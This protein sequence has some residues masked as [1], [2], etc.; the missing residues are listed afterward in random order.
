MRSYFGTAISKNLAY[1]PEGFLVARNCIV[2][3]TAVHTPQMYKESEL[4]NGG[5]NRQVP[6]YRPKSSVLDPRYLASLEGKILTSPHPP[7]FLSPQNAAAFGK[8]VIVNV[9]PGPRIEDEDTVMADLIVYDKQLIADIVSGK[10]R[11]LSVGYEC[12]YLPEDG[13]DGYVQANIVA[14]HL[15]CVETARAGPGARI[16]DSKD[17]REGWDMSEMSTAEAM[18]ILRRISDALSVDSARE[19]TDADSYV[20]ADLQ[21]RFGYISPAA[22]EF[23]DSARRFHR[24]FAAAGDCRPALRER[25]DERRS[26]RVLDESPE[27]EAAIDAAKLSAEYSESMRQHHRK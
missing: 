25:A 22:Q 24:S 12:V 15:A 3:R 5:S 7:Q 26:A 6:V 4:V 1:T 23:A 17:N 27:P 20:D 13:G 18:A 14:N 9:R 10:L 8:G 16:Y 2:A 19:T 21:R 11:E